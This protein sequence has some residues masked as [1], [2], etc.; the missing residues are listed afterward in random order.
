MF[1]IR[2]NLEL[3]TLAAANLGVILF[4]A[5]YAI[6]A[7]RVAYR[8]QREQTIQNWQLNQVVATAPREAEATG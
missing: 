8:A 4:V 1:D 3:A 6:G 5:L 2:G 7:N